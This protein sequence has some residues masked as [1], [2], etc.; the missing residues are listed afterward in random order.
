LHDGGVQE[1]VT[2]PA[3]G[4]AALTVPTLPKTVL[5]VPVAFTTA[6]LLEFQVS[7]TPVNVIP[8]LS[9]TVAFNVVEVPVPTR[10]DVC[11]PLRGLIEID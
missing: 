11:E 2:D 10:N 7:G 9:V 4:P 5:V 8:K 3:P 6:G 1:A